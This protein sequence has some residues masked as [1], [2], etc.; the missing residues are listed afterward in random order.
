M[1]KRKIGIARKLSHL[2]KEIHAIPA[3]K[4]LMLAGL[5]Q[6]SNF[7]KT[8]KFTTR[9]NQINMQPK[10][11]RKD[12]TP[13][14]K[15]PWII[16]ANLE[17]TKAKEALARIQASHLTPSSQSRIALPYAKRASNVVK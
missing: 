6:K 14:D 12:K 5:H 9:T 15:N 4:N 16:R 3:S 11:N 7:K 17:F 2:I 1:K 10:I 8:T 13:V